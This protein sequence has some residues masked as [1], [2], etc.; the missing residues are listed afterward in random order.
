MLNCC[1]MVM[2]SCF[3]AAPTGHDQAFVIGTRVASSLDYAAQ[4]WKA[5]FIGSF[6]F[7]FFFLFFFFFF[8]LSVASFIGRE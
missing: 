1:P 2:F 8:P 3:L 5:T 4:Y 7:F 6:F